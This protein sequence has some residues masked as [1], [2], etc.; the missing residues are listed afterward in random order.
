MAIF[1]VRMTESC[2]YAMKFFYWASNCESILDSG[3]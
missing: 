2:S 1:V 3:S